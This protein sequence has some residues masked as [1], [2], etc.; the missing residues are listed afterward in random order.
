MGQTAQRSEQIVG[1]LILLL[2]LLD[3]FLTVLYARMDT[4]IISPRVSRIVWWVLATV[5]KPFGPR[6]GA[7][8]AYCGPLILVTLVLVW[9]L[10]LA[11]AA[12]LIIH[13]ALGT[14]VR[15][16]VGE[17][18]P[19]DFITALYAAGSS[20]SIVGASTFTPHT[21]AFR[22]LY[23]FN[24]LIGI[25]VTSL[26]LTYLMQVYS[27]LNRRNT[28]ALNVHL[29][30]GE[31]GDAAEVLAG[32]G[33]EGKF[34]TGYPDL[35]RLANQITET[36]ESHHFYPVLVYFRFRAPY[37]SIS[38]FALVVLD[39]ATL[40]RS[41]LDDREYGWLK[42]SGAVGQLWSSSTLM[43]EAL[44]YTFVRPAHREAQPE[45]GE[46]VR[47]LWRRRYLAALPRLRQAGIRTVD[48][49]E[50]GARIYVELRSEWNKHIAAMGPMLS[51]S[52]E[53]V[54]PVIYHLRHAEKNDSLTPLAL[55]TRL[56]YR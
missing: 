7:I 14:A 38:R 45:A 27:A 43:L 30:S 13:P 33:P 22:L 10:G 1:I 28:L 18:T 31:D 9:A 24:S 37:Y 54:D 48:D 20:I 42:K 39:T 8:L 41:A 25:S 50:R 56:R 3:V 46:E 6:R 12:A 44:S 53:E 5:S 51:Y 52:E 47:E 23:L 21:G 19:G 55:P 2:I 15:A 16:N 11:F 32:L 4:G 26:T 34:D 29:A 36:K 17:S 40:I 35:S 49:V